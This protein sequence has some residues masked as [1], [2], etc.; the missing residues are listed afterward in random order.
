MKSSI[1]FAAIV[2]ILIIAAYTICFYDTSLSDDTSD[3]GAFGSYVGM[4]ISFLSVTLI[5]VTY[6][7]QRQANRIGMFE[8]QMRFMFDRLSVLIERDNDGIEDEA[9]KIET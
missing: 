9:K 3:W 7:E 5:F 2:F 6:N 8:Q 1:F 4:G